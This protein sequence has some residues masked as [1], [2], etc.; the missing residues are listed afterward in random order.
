M[1]KK[2]GIIL[3]LI[4]AR[5]GSKGVE[6]KNIKMLSGKPLIAYSIECGLACPSID[7]LIVSTDDAK[8]AAISRE[9][10]AEIP[11]MRPPELAQDNTP[12]LPVLQHAIEHAETAYNEQV[13]ALVLLQPTSP[14]RKASD[15]ENAIS[16]YY[17]DDA[18]QAVV[19]GREAHFNPYFSMAELDN[20]YVRL[21]F[22]S[23][24]NIYGRQNCPAV[25]DLDGTVWVYSRTALMDQQQRIPLNT[26]LYTVPGKRVVEIDSEF[27]FEIAEILISRSKLIND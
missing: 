19:S 24:K 1:K 25:Y 6:R 10:G 5:G 12:M 27:D 17:E 15:V 11:F 7:K 4:P 22:E 3:G 21:L 23:G 14:L 16:L 2:D 8:I 13:H 26:R 9:H 18:C 20:G